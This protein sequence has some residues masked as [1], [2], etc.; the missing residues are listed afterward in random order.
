MNK[1]IV[2]S[3]IVVICVLV[4]IEMIILAVKDQTTTAK[5]PSASVVSS[6]VPATVANPHTTALAQALAQPHV[7][8]AA[9]TQAQAAQAQALA[10]AQAAFVEDF[11]PPVDVR[12]LSTAA[13]AFSFME[14]DGRVGVLLI[15]AQWCGACKFYKGKFNAAATAAREK[16][17]PISFARFDNSKGDVS[18]LSAAHGNTGLPFI[19]MKDAAGK[20]TPLPRTSHARTPAGLLEALDGLK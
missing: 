3:V 2:I 14:A 8:Q 15:Y 18:K 1:K 5:T 11:P 16:G 13:E 17:L 6:L 7:A 10:Q 9:Q 12:E 4:V 20:Q 19:L